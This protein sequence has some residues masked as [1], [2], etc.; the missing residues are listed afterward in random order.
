MFLVGLEMP[1]QRE[2]LG[3]KAEILLW[4]DLPRSLSQLYGV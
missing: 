4:L 2:H 1:G 3:K